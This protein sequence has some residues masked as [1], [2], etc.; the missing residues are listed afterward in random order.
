MTTG[1]GEPALDVQGLTVSYGPERAL[2]DV[3][4]TV[5][6]GEVVAVVGESGSGKSTLAHAVIGLLPPGGRIDAGRALVAG[7]DTVAL[8]ERALRSLRGAAVGFVPQDPAASLDPV[9]RVGDQVA[10]ALRVH[11]RAGRSAA[12]R[13]AVDLLAEAGLGDP[14]RC[15]RAHPHELSGGQRQRALIAAA[16]ACRPRLLIADEP[17]SALDVTVQ[18]RILDRL[19]A[20]VAERGTAVLFITHD[21]AVAAGRADR[22]AVMSGGRVVECGP[23]ADVLERPRHAYTQSLVAAARRASGPPHRP[24]ARRTTPLLVVEALTK[25]YAGGHR[26]VDG[27]SFVVGHGEV[28]G[29]VG[30]SGS[31][32]STTARL[33]TGLDRPTSGSVHLAVERSGDRAQ[34]VQQSPYAALDPRWSV[35]RSVEEPLRAQGIGDR[36]TRRLR[37]AE[38]LDQ[39]ALSRTLLDRRPAELSGGQRQRVAI[40]RALAPAPSLL[41][42]DEPV[43]ALDV[44]A[45]ARI[46]ELLAAL[47]ADL[48]LAVLLISHDLGVV[49]ELCDRVAVMRAGRLVEQGPARQVLVTP[50][51]PYTRELV[52]AAPVLSESQPWAS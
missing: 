38:L 16:L 44:S 50:E 28:F 30:E 27:V 29:L 7:Q 52:D 12:R 20:L 40:A 35:R 23:A 21:L 2:K 6:A 45:Q 41:V 4:L 25:E 11:G 46:L 17:T 32:K 5:G 1:T 14:E 8:P 48:G 9:Q 10:E 26:A 42:C 13:Q 36:R 19:G 3:D 24:A 39:V 22:I 37:V 51:H 33:V 15:A 34:L 49:R 43:S 31:G 47:R 18:R